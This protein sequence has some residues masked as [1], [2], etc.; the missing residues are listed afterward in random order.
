MDVELDPILVIKRRDTQ[1]EAGIEEVLEQLKSYQPIK[2]DKAPAL[3]TKVG[4]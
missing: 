1:L 4:D 2:L 3:P